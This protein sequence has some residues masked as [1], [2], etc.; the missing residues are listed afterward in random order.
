M[1]L[2]L[3]FLLVLGSVFVFSCS[4]KEEVQKLSTFISGQITVDEELDRS[5]DYSSIELLVSFLSQDGE[6]RDTIFHAVTN[7][8]GYFSGTA[9]FDE[10]EIYPVIISRN[11]NTFGVQNMIFADGDT[12]TFN[13][14]LPNVSQTAEITSKENDVFRIFERVERNFNRVAQFI[15][16][17]AL[18]ADSIDIEILKWSDIFWEVFDNNRTTYAGMI[19]G[20]SSI[21]MLR[22]WNDSLM[23]QRSEKLL[24]SEKYLQRPSRIALIDYYAESEGLDKI[25]AFLDHIE[26][27]AQSENEKMNIRIDRIEILYDSSR[28]REANQYLDRFRDT[29]SNNRAAIDWAENISYDL[30]FLTP[31][32]PFPFLAFQTVTGDSIFTESLIG[33]PFLIEITRLDNFIYQQQYDRT[34]AIYQIYNNFGL[35]IITVPIS[36]SQVTLEAFFSERNMFWKVVQPG[37]FN[38]DE[39]IE[40]LNLTQVPTRFLVNDNGEIIRRYIGN[41]YDEVVRGLQQIITQND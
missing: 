25:L 31:G 5:G 20:N 2:K 9:R 19:A 23:V 37:S 39:L 6:A 29:Y 1:N 30:E 36:A 40:I 13:A 34:V 11:R 4:K 18:S 8:D 10:R 15:N 16:A 14:Q 28:T 17:G 7:S 33:K 26:R 24:E 21:E 41:E 35:E 32:S 12:I 3:L 27:I 38:T 22:G